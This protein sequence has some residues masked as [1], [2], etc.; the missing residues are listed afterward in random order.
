MPPNV[1][2]DQRIPDDDA[3]AA[4]LAAAGVDGSPAFITALSGGPDSTALALLVQRFANRHNRS[5]LALI[6]D[7]GLRDGSAEE[8]RRVKER[9]SHFGVN[10]RIQ[11]IVAPPPTASIQEWARR[12]RQDLLAAAARAEE[13]VVLFGHHADDQ[14]E[15]VAMRLQHG[16]GLGGIRGM[17]LRRWHH[18]VLFARPLLGWRR[19]SLIAVCAAHGCV[20]EIDPSNQNQI[21]ER[22]RIRQMLAEID[23]G[24][25]SGRLDVSSAGL[26]RLANAAGSLVGHL[27]RATMALCDSAIK[28]HRAGY[29][30]FDP[31]PLSS[32]PQLVW[33]HVMRR[34]IIAMGGAKY[35]P[36]ASGGR[37]CRARL[38]HWLSA[39]L[40]GCHFHPF[41]NGYQLF[42]ETGRYPEQRQ[43]IAGRPVVLP[44]AG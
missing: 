24:N 12:H 10:I 28:W 3:F 5:H 21:F 27:D 17:P 43:I 42:R 20:Y 6:V 4:A 39:T 14:A 18:D 13:A 34:V 40:G 25:A 35:G 1:R 37:E 33:W 23:Q 22:V 11:P 7:H 15:T 38:D 41:N 8:A 30:D 29:A 2:A 31:Q 9:L 44:A 26:T 36:S 19:S 32:L 16:S